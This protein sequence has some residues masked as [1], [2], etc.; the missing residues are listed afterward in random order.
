MGASPSGQ[1]IKRN[2]NSAKPKPSKIVHA[3]PAKSSVVAL[4][5]VNLCNNKTTSVIIRLQAFEPSK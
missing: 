5:I 1:C 4:K 2:Y 3:G